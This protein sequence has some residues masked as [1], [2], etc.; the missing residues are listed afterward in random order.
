MA[1]AGGILHLAVQVL[2]EVED[3]LPALVNGVLREEHGAQLGVRGTGLR[4]GRERDLALE[5]LVAQVVPGL[6]HVFLSDEVL[7]VDEDHRQRGL[8]DPHVVRVLVRVADHVVVRADIRVKVIH[9]ASQGVRAAAPE[10]VALR[11]LALSNDALAELA[12]A[13]RDDLHVDVRIRGLEH[14]H[15]RVERIRVM[16][17]IDDEAA[18][19]QRRRSG[20]Q[21]HHREDER[22]KLLHNGYPPFD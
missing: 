7:V 12:G 22:K 21:Q 14:R 20:H 17:R 8:A 11:I 5:S 19:G 10:D 4:R 6:G 15:A 13:G 3:Q 18:I 1:V 16:R 2:D 9:I